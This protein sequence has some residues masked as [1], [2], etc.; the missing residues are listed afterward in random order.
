MGISKIFIIGLLI[1]L[2]FIFI[3]CCSDNLKTVAGVRLPR[4]IYLD[5]NLG[6][7]SNDGLTQTTA[8]KTFSKIDKAGLVPGDTVEF[9]R[10]SVFNS[11]LYIND[12]GENGKF[13]VLTCYGDPNQDA[14]KFTNPVFDPAKNIYGNCI[15]LRG[16]YIIIEDLFFE[17][18]AAELSGSIGFITMWELGAIY[19]DRTASNCI[20]RNNELFNCGVGIKSYG[21][22]ALIEN[23]YIHDCSRILKQWS[24]GPIG[25]WIGG[26]YQEVCYNRIFNYSAVDPRINWGPGSYGGGADGGAIEIDDGRIPKSHIAIHHNYTRGNQGFI[27]V[28]WT[29]VVQN[30]PYSGFLIHHNVSD[31][32][33][34]FVALWCG[35][36]CRFEN[37]TII[38]R[39]VNANDWGVFNIT[40]Y[41][42]GN[43]IRNN[44]ITVEKDV[45]IFNVGRDGIAQP[46]S[47]IKNNL[48][49]AF[50]G[51]LK[52]GL[53][54]PGEN[55]IFSDPKFL[56]YEFGNQ[57]KDFSLSNLSP[58]IDMGLDLGYKIDF[59]GLNIP[60]GNS[61]DLGAFE[62]PESINHFIRK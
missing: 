20:V 46:H 54:G 9:K 34:Q 38:R 33:Q 1:Y 23:N 13:I 28:T 57:A 53:E 17:N 47:I 2:K 37:N 5:S 39:R 49:Y 8:W 52:I 19:L 40:Q 61:P 35:S 16:S 22:H 14:P 48:F 27:E 26:D 59:D 62:Y 44:I 36:E 58:A 18:T 41:N 29:D 6:D 43:L 11:T 45:V 32:Y 24:W 10:G 12:S 7:D 30:P 25:I 4:V 15:R 50:S 56:N 60:Q 55:A 21:P 3:S 31:D 51:E 42:S